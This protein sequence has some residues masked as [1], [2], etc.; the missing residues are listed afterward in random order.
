MSSEILYI[1][2]LCPEIERIRPCSCVT[3]RRGEINEYTTIQ[4][5]NELDD[6]DRLPQIMD[7]LNRRTELPRHFESLYLYNTGI[8]ELKENTLKGITFD[9][10]HVIECENL[11]TIHENAFIGTENVTKVITIDGNPKLT[12]EN[13]SIF[14]FLS[15][16]I[17]AE[18]IGLRNNSKIT[19][20]PTKVVMPAK[21]N[22]YEIKV[23]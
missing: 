1:A 14:Q 19:E 2:I 13:S 6:D 21:K 3:H 20:I 12:F 8:H 22:F 9:E 10:I 23:P 16:F 15:K 17:N 7:I 11:T 4:C 5:W 18:Q